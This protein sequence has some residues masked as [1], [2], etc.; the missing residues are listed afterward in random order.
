MMELAELKIMVAFCLSDWETIYAINWAKKML[1]IIMEE[2]LAFRAVNPACFYPSKFGM[3]MVSIII[4]VNIYG[5]SI[6]S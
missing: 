3:Q 1:G 2:N 6:M 4:I 5:V